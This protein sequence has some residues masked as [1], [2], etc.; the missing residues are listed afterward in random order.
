M[1]DCIFC[2]QP[3]KNIYLF[4]NSCEEK[5]LKSNTINT[6]TSNLQSDYAE[7]RF[8]LVIFLILNQTD[9]L[10]RLEQSKI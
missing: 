4:C 9:I 5:M 1:N 2:E 6:L 7:E 10:V 3:S 8:I